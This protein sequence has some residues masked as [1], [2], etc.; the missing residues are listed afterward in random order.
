MARTAGGGAVSVVHASLL[1]PL[2]SILV[3]RVWCEG[4]AGRGHVRVKLTGNSPSRA[5]AVDLPRPPAGRVHWNAFVKASQR[6][7]GATTGR[8]VDDDGAEVTSASELDEGSLTLLHAA[9]ASDFRASR[10]GLGIKE[11]HGLKAS[12]G[13]TLAR[14]QRAAPLMHA[15]LP[16][17]SEHPYLEASGER[18]GLPK[19][20]ISEA[21]TTLGERMKKDL[22][23]LN[24][25]AK[26]TIRELFWA[27]A[28]PERHP[29]P[30]VW[31]T[32]F[33]LIP[34]GDWSPASRLISGPC[35][36]RGS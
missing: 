10:G 31:L 14:Q 23:M 2:I 21:M 35:R 18:T 32:W 13:A 33:I 5:A 20:G 36:Q 9:H 16:F 34:T 19:D 17:S 6:A 29:T 30:A 24:A 25:T 3:C 15:P 1:V 22:S 12:Q 11:R 8:L 4:V 28:P 7:L 26:A 27:V